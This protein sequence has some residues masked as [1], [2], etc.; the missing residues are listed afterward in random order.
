MLQCKI[1]VVAELQQMEAVMEIRDFIRHM[2]DVIRSLPS[3]KV[4]GDQFRTPLGVPVKIDE[5][6][7]RQVIERILPDKEG[8]FIDIGVNMGQTLLSLRSVDKS[9][10]YIG[11]EPNPHCVSVV[12]RIVDMNKLYNI[13]LIPLACADKFGI[14][15]LYHY[16]DTEFD[17]SASMLH[18]FR[19]TQKPLRSSVIAMGAAIDCLQTVGVDNVGIVKIDVEG[20]EANVLEAIEPVLLRDRPIILIEI[21]P[22]REDMNRIQAGKR[23]Q[24]VLDRIGYV[25]RKIEKTSDGH[26]RGFAEGIEPGFQTNVVESDFIFSCATVHL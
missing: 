18:D 10:H 12:Q 2:R 19:P 13:T 25:S 26:F 1:E 11:F 5:L 22:M 23:I 14:S 3:C 24:G 15:A 7:M 4:G 21:L 6:W 16:L 20:F 17:S 8:A 9:R